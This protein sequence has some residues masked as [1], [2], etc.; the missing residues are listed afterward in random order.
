MLGHT[1]HKLN[2]CFKYL[3]T[4]HLFVVCVTW[5]ART[6]LFITTPTFLLVV[7]LFLHGLSYPSV[8]VAVTVWRFLQAS[9]ALSDFPQL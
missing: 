3:K 8:C 4:G 6:F 7:E 1:E 5:F 2:L 9:V